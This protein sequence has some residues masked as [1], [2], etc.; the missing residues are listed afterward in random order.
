MQYDEPRRKSSNKTVWIIL[1]IGGAVLLVIVVA[2]AGFGF[3]A[4]K[5]LTTDLPAAQASC[6]AF[7]DL[8][9]ADRVDAA[10]ASTTKGFQSTTTTEKFREFVE[11][12]ATLKAHNSRTFG[13]G[14]IFQ[15]TGGKQ[16]T[17]HVTLLSANNATSCT[18]ILMQEDG[19]WKVHQVNIP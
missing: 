12:Y 17:L 6:D 5:S 11:R 16:A 7:F 4:M 19:Q 13:N 10:Y 18:V 14:N 2:C 8:L 9:K 1:G 3:W 15:G